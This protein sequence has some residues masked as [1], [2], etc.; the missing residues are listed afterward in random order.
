MLE[1]KDLRLT[2]GNRLELANGLTME[3]DSESK[4][5]DWL[6]DTDSV[7]TSLIDLKNWTIENQRVWI[8]WL[9]T[10]ALTSDSDWLW[11]WGSNQGIWLTCWYRCPETKDS[12][13]Q[14]KLILVL[15]SPTDLQKLILEPAIGLVCRNGTL[16]STRLGLTDGDWGFNQ[17]LWLLAE[18]DLELKDWLTRRT[19]SLYQRG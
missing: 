10:E 1:S 15:T 9:E 6:A 16:E 14:R 4:E 17:W 12:I 11:D 3:T 5:S 8:D 2:G 18:T 13:H 19:R 7:L